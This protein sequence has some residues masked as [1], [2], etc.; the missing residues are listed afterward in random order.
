MSMPS[1]N[2]VSPQGQP[3]PNSQPPT[4]TSYPTVSSSPMLPTGHHGGGTVMVSTATNVTPCSTPNTSNTLIQGPPQ[5]STGYM[6]GGTGPTQTYHIFLPTS[7]PQVAP[8]GLPTGGLLQPAPAIP[9]YPM[10]GY[11]NIGMMPQATEW[12]QPNYK[13]SNRGN[14]SSNYKGRGRGGRGGPSND[15]NTPVG[16]NGPPQGSFAPTNSYQPYQQTVAQLPYSQYQGGGQQQYGQRRQNH[17]SWETSSQHS[18]SSQKKFSSSSSSGHDSGSGVVPGVGV[19]SPQAAPRLVQQPVAVQYAPQPA[20]QFL[21]QS[22]VHPHHQARPSIPK[23]DFQGGVGGQYQPYHHQGHQQRNLP[24]TIQTKEYVSKRGRG[25]RG[26]SS[27][28][29]RDDMSGGGGGYNSTRGSHNAGAPPGGAPARNV[30]YHQGRHNSGGGPGGVMPGPQDV[31][32]PQPRPEPPRPAPEFNMETN[33]FPALPGAPAPPPAADPTRFLDVVKGTAKIKLDDDQEVLAEDLCN[34]IYEESGGQRAS[35]PDIGSDAV[36]GAIISPK[37]RSKNPSVSETPVVSVERTATEEEVVVMAPLVNGE[38]K[39]NAKASVPV[40]SINANS[41]RDSGS[42]SPR[43]QSLDSGQK[44]TYAQ[45]IQKKKEA[46][47][48]LERERAAAAAAGQTLETKGNKDEK[49]EKT[50]EAESGMAKEG[51]SEGEVDQGGQ[52]APVE[53]QDSRSKHRPLAKASSGGGVGPK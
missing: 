18:N 15:R 22:A 31:T 10:S 41:D 33:D 4:M 24:D 8:Y 19:V 45:I 12:L 39:T 44:L 52:H 14:H 40:V 13:S 23:D 25:G 7:Q 48:A 11:F 38:V 6:A 2:V 21:P 27:R 34:S 17:N 53:R 36:A 32:S 9:G 46:A 20:T 5:A 29:G 30:V 47:E 16:S 26:G 1:M 43:Q 37:S 42:I 3:M 51:A 49:V 28:G 50:V 35:I